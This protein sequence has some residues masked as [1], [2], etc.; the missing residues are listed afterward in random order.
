MNHIKHLIWILMT[1]KGI[2]SLGSTAESTANNTST[3]PASLHATLSPLRKH[4]RD[5]VTEVPRTLHRTAAINV[6]S[7]LN[8]TGAADEES[9]DFD[10]LRKIDH[11]HHLTFMIW[12]IWSPVLLGKNYVSFH[13][14][15]HKLEEIGNIGISS[16]T[17]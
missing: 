8:S 2:Y 3:T 7:T 5:N 15:F 1:V 6:S 4:N 10:L 14:F 13:M 9:I 17:T 16:L 11:Y 12:R